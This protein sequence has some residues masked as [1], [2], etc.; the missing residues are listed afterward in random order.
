MDV[1]VVGVPFNS[2]GTRGG[3]ARMP[4][5]LRAHGLVERLTAAGVAVRDEG[6]VPAGA[7]DPRRDEASGIIAVEAVAEVAV[8]VR[9]RV[10]EVLRAGVFPLVVAGECSVLLGALAALRGE[11][12]AAGLL[13]VD[14]HEDTWPPHASL[15]GDVADMEL[16]LAL[17]RHVD[18]LPGSLRAMLPVIGPDDVVL[19]GPRDAAEMEAAGVGSLRDELWLADDVQLHTRLEDVVTGAAAHLDRRCAAWWL[20]VDLDVLSTAALPAVDAPQPGGLSWAE[21]GELTRTALRGGHVK[22][23][24]VTIYDPDLDESGAHATRIV[25]YLVETLGG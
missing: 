13:F 2:D 23:M 4:S 8:G 24:D 16:G 10:A 18:G 1:G 12:G 11:Y 9:R 22:G 6:D 25:D 21:L 17:G 5:V 15:S 20:H 7:S 14:G 3:V 19:L